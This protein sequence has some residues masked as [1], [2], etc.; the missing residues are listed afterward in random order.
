MAKKNNYALVTL[1][2]NG[3]TIPAYTMIKSFLK[4]NAWFEGDVVI[5]QKG[6][7]QKEAEDNLKS[8]Y[9]KIIFYRPNE[10]IYQKAIKR[11]EQCNEKVL[12]LCELY[13][14]HMLKFE[15]FGMEQYDRVV[16]Y[17]SDMLFVGDVKEA[18]FNNYHFALCVDDNTALR[19]KEPPRKWDNNEYLN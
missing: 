14:P 10:T 16:F 13:W 15:V 11:F 1:A 18:F 12:N 8:L 5:I 4:H 7:F 17:D 3:Y 19:L 9:D 2:D 6:E